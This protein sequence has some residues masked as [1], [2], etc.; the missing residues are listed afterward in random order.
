MIDARQTVVFRWLTAGDPG[1]LDAFDDLLYPNVVVHAPL[2]LSTASLDEEK[3]VWRDALATMP[4]IRHDV[5]E[6]VVD[7]E[8]EMAGV[9]VTGTMA[10]D[11]AGV[12][13]SGRSFRIDQAVITH[14]ATRRS[15]RRGRSLVSLPFVPK[16]GTRAPITRGRKG[17]NKPVERRIRTHEPPRRRAVFEAGPLDWDRGCDDPSFGRH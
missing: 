1:D 2:G 13:G 5:Q 17:S 10:A 8:T 3:T 4:D 6:V 12:E 15:S 7:G 11:F 9:V 14:L 16:S